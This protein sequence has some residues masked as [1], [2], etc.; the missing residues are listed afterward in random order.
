MED[1]QSRRIVVQG[2]KKKMMVWKREG[3]SSSE[4]DSK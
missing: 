4:V 2:I 3:K 1:V